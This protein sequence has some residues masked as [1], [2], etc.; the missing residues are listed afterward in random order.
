[1]TSVCKERWFQ[2]LE[3]LNRPVSRWG[4]SITA[5]A[6]GFRAV[7]GLPF[8]ETYFLALAGVA[9]FTY[10]QRGNEKLKEMELER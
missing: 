10:W 6:Y 1:M 7:I 5:V 4:F 8:E 2:L 3:K 9:G